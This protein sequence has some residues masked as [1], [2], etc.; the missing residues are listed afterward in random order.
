MAK[1]N[2]A[3]VRNQAYTKNSLG[4]RE[5]HNERKN[6]CYSNADILLDRSHLNV[7]FKDCEG[8]YAEA[9]DRLAD[10]GAVSLRGLSTKGDKP[11]KVVDEFIFDVNT[12]YF[13]NHGGY[14]YAK[15]FFAEAYRL[16]VAEAG[17]EEYVLSAVLH[18]DEKNTALSEELGR[19]VFHYHL[20]VIYIP[21]VEKEI[22]FRKNNK[23][24]DLAGKLKGVI[25]Q[26]SHSKKWPRYKDETGAWV[27]SYSLLQDRFY[28][29]MKEAGFTDFE[30]GERGSTAEHL[31]VLEFKTK[32]EIERAAAVTAEVGEKIQT[33]A[34]DKKVEQKQNQLAALDKKTAAAKKEA[35]TA[36][37][38]EKMAKPALLG[39]NLTISPADWD[40]VK[41]IAKEG[42]K[43]RER[44]S[45]LR[46]RNSALLQENGDLKARLAKAEP[47]RSIS[48]DLKF[49]QAR[50]RAPRRMAEVIADIL[51]KPRER[52]EPEHA[53]ERKR[54]AEMEH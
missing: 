19:D 52:T 25:K 17:G 22:H 7:H 54:S 9:F 20:H 23:N 5:R 51:R 26:V 14:E 18:A 2:R 40:K 38:I 45:A 49:Y 6:E 42:V 35:A 24:P 39:G 33:A 12:A 3:V 41:N 36:A 44:I 27:N 47:K 48:E 10:S 34:L 16:A 28:Q 30:R 13:E 31:N 43:S 29:H 53:P 8:S 37:D 46:E 15:A 21:V 4:V 50:Q 11:P 32:Q 1:T